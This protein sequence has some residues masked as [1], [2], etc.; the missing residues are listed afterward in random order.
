[1]AKI[2]EAPLLKPCHG[3]D[4]SGWQAAASDGARWL[5]AEEQVAVILACCCWEAC[6]LAS[7]GPP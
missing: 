7:S 6:G 2:V 1:V 3:Q 4:Q 5:L